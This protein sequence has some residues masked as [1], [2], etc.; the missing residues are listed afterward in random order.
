MNK[1]RHFLIKSHDIRIIFTAVIYFSSAYLGLIL[2]FQDPFTSPVWP[3]VGVGFALMMLLGPRVWPGITIGSLLAYMLVFWL[4]HV[5]ISLATIQASIIIAVG[6]TSELLVGYFLSKLFI[7]NEDPFRKTNETFMFLLIALVMCLIGSSFGT[8]SLYLNEMVTREEF[9]Q[10]W[11]YWWI[12]NVASVLLFTP[13]ILAWQRRFRIRTSKAKI[14]EFIFFLLC[15]SIFIAILHNQ[16]LGP[17]IEKSLP[18]LVIPFLLWLSFRFNLQTSMA[19]ILIAALSAIF[20]TINGIGPFVLETNENS[21]LIL[22]IFIGVI[23]ISSIVLSSTVF[24]RWVA[25]ETI[26]SFNETLES[27]IEERTKELNAEI[28]FRKNAEDKIKIANEQLQKT[29]IELDNFVYKVSHDLRAPIASVLGLVNLA[30]KENKLDVLREYFNMIGKS[31]EQQDVFIKDILDLSRNSRLVVNK[32]KIQWE[33]LLSDT[34]DN[35]KYSVKDK[36]IEKIINI[37]GRS[38][39]YSDQRRI[40]VIFNNLISNS[41]RYANGKDPKV[42]I[43]INV[44]KTAADIMISDNG[45][46][47]EKPHQKKVFE[48][49]YRATD[50]NVGSGLGLYIVKESVERLNGHIELTS[51]KGQGTVFNISL[52]NLK[53]QN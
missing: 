12:P 31:A 18:F 45:I 32:D 51:E 39:F 14:L 28:I 10:T 11:F 20:F 9:L 15:L 3:P 35:L 17:T 34:F 43:D 4:K 42:E 52:P 22:Q 48:M 24:E 46:G 53:N 25:Q 7:K 38:S 5:E 49:F 23:S 41:I 36:R 2:A 19:G 33:E 30:K 50:S 1:I 21:I 6:N 37:H 40:K 26:K 44:N 27:K 13:F 29:N 8:Y 47:I 16:Q